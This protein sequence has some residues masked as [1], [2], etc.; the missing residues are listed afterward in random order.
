[1]FENRVLKRIF[2]QKRD[3]IKVKGKAIHVTGCEGPRGC[4]GS[5]LPYI[6]DSRLIDGSKNV[7]LTCH[8]PFIPQKNSW[9]SFRLAAELTPGPQCGWK[10]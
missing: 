9:Y 5:R 1:V 6:L 3:E 2:G 10:D 4:E 7:S 8:P